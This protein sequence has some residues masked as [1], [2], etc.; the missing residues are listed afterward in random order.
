MKLTQLF[1][2]K[3]KPLAAGTVEVITEIRSRKAL[4]K[5]GVL[6]RAICNSANFSS[7]YTYAKGVIQIFNVGA[8][9]ML[10]YTAS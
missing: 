2:R 6:Q 4:F 1:R 5:A 7:I 8:E 3:A 10:C 9:Q